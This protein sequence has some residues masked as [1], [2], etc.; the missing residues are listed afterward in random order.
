MQ[1]L[2]NEMIYNI[3]VGQ[4]GAMAKEQTQT[5]A[6]S[7]D[8]C[9]LGTAHRAG[10]VV[11][12][13]GSTVHVR[14]MRAED[15]AS[16]LALFQSLSEE[17]LWL[18]FYSLLKGKALAA[19]AHRETNLDHAFGLVA[20]SGGDRRIVG[21]AFYAGIEAHRAEVAFTINDDVHRRIQGI[22]LFGEL[23]KM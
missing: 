5:Q 6:A 17:S 9:S 14:A 21:H 2:N 8:F 3:Q 22:S 15:D 13:D 4:Q 19:E 23:A 10:D 16:L 7:G 18:R 20:L 11:L 1:T 12:K